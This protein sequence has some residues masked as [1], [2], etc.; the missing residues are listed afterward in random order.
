MSAGKQVSLRRDATDNR[1]RILEAARALFVTKGLSPGLNDVAHHAGVGVATVY[2]RF[3]TKSELIHQ[4]YAEAL[5]HCIVKL[6]SAHRSEDA[7]TAMESA[8]ISLCE[9]SA[10]DRGF[11]EMAFEVSGAEFCP[12]AARERLIS[13]I[14]A[15]VER[16]KDQGCIRRDLSHTDIPILGMLAGSVNDYAGAVAPDLWRRYVVLMLDGVRRRPAQTHMPARAFTDAQ[17]NSVLGL[18]PPG[19]PQTLRPRG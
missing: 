4:V 7:W 18:C 9:M 13:V 10:S 11:R 19:G 6:E 8:L 2:R 12:A 1:R 5:D 16:A 15:V 14:A 3:P 17:L